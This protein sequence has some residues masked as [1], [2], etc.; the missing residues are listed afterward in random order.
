MI[1]LTTP[2]CWASVWLDTWLPSFDTDGSWHRLPCLVRV[3]GPHAGDADL[4]DAAMIIVGCF[5]IKLHSPARTL[6]NR[7]QKVR[8]HSSISSNLVQ[9]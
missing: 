6:G 7:V 5:I 8:G 3:V 1:R 2:C 9:S 4:T